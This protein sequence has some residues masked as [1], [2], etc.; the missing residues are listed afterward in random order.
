M[1]ARVERP[2][3]PSVSGQREARELH[4][5]AVAAGAQA[6][7]AP[8][9]RLDRAPQLAAARAPSLCD[10]GTTS[11]RSRAG[12]GEVAEHEHRVDR[13]ARDSL[14]AP[15]APAAPALPPLVDTSTSVRLERAPAEHPRELE[16]RRGA[17]QLGLRAAP[18]RVAMRDDDDAA[19]R[20]ARRARR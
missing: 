1:P 19:A 20:E 13:P 8:H 12:A 14:P 11:G 17:R 2:C 16:Q 10:H 18:E 5:R 3:S 4:R 15:R 7:L 9:G 6:G